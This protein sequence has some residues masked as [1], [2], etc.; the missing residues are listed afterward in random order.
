MCLTV[1][2]FMNGELVK[3]CGKDERFA[4]IQ[5]VSKTGMFYYFNKEIKMM[6]LLKTT[7]HDCDC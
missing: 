7:K 4:V 5:C 6:G 2:I 3:E 1:F